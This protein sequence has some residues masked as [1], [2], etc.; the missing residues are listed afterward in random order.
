[1]Q[2]DLLLMQLED[3]QLAARDVIGICKEF[4]GEEADTRRDSLPAF[5]LMLAEKLSRL[6]S[7][8]G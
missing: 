8:A 7:T 3:V 6:E 4:L 5:C 2:R 1:V